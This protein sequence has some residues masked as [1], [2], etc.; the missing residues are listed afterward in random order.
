MV[1]FLILSGRRFSEHQLLIL[2]SL[3]CNILQSV[4]VIIRN[5]K[6][7]EDL[8][9]IKTL[10]CSLVRS[11]LE[12]ASVIWNPIYKIHETNL[13]RVQRRFL[14]YMV[15]RADG[16]YPEQGYPEDIMLERFSLHS[17][18]SRRKLDS[19]LLLVKILRF[20]I[21][22]SELLSLL[23]FRTSIGR[24]RSNN[25]FE[26]TVP[27]TKVLLASPLFQSI[28]N[29]THVADQFDIFSSTLQHIKHQ[30]G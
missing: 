20:Q 14:K 17:L 21:D 25:L 5:S 1:H 30:I 4:G 23:R 18:M 22:C 29:Y 12:Y 6:E 11:R 10:Y 27:R 15:F 28:K 7:I 13:E 9:V 2:S 24:L 16:A 8:S 3:F 26:L 19:I